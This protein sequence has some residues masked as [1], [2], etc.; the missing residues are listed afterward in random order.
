MMTPP[1]GFVLITHAAPAQILRLVRRLN[2]MYGDPPIVCHHD[3][4][5]VDLPLDTFPKNVSF[6][7]PYLKTAWAE[8]P[9]V[10]GTARAIRQ[11]FERPDAPDWFILLSGSDYPVRPAKQVRADLESGGYDAHLQHDAIIPGQ[12]RNDWERHCHRRYFG[13]RVLVPWLSSR[14][15]R[16]RAWRLPAAIDFS[17]G[18]PF[19]SNFVC[20]AGSQWF[21]ASRAAAKRIVDSYERDRAFIRFS[22][23]IFFI[24]E[25]YFQTI[26]GNAAGL[27]LSPRRFR[28]IDFGAGGAHPKALRLEDLPKIL[29]SG[30]HFA[31]K[32][33]GG[34]TEVL[35][36]IDAAVDAMA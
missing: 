36:A 21:S 35:D 10:E 31:R 34:S 20:Y 3:F 24:E 11:L 13:Q 6:V 5:K 4:S 26:L 1:I 15:F 9:V 30:D 17:G 18:Y 23:K 22:R 8:F 27:R 25:M 12:F 28:Y 16:W 7:R 29:A 33:D 19:K 14:G 2:T 32:F